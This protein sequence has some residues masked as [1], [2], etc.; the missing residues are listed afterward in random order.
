MKCVCMWKS[1]RMQGL[2]VI[3][4]CVCQVRVRGEKGP[5][6]KVANCKCRYQQLYL[7]SSG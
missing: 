6:G 4:D 2:H 1:T 5:Y 7:L 3:K